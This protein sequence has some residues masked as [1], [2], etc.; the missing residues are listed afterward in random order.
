MSPMH[1]PG[2]F[3]QIIDISNSTTVLQ[4]STFLEYGMNYPLG[5][6]YRLY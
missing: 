3:S 5:V 1:V 2:R 4:A 6:D